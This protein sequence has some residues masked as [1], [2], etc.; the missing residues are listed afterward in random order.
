[1]KRLEDGDL[2]NVPILPWL[3]QEDTNPPDRIKRI[4]LFRQKNILRAYK[5]KEKAKLR[6]KQQ[7]QKES[8]M[9]QS[10]QLSTWL[11]SKF[12]QS[13]II[14][15]IKMNQQ[16]RLRQAQEKKKQARIIKAKQKQQPDKNQPL[17][18]QH[19]TATTQTPQ[20]AT[21]TTTKQ[22]EHDPHN[23]ERRRKK[24][25]EQTISDQ[26][27]TKARTITKKVKSTVQSWYSG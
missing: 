13:T 21:H 11:S 6:R 4:K 16:K 20:L 10:Q 9:T 15:R 25:K 14:Q 26:F 27:K 23:K 24:T 7:K 17:I 18:E 22:H 19:F 2:G 5:R 1:M 12:S 8:T 3:S